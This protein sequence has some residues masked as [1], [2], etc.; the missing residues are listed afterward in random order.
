MRS[1]RDGRCEPPAPGGSN[2]TISRSSTRSR[3]GSHM[4]R[5]A[6]IPVTS[7]SGGPLP[8]RATR[9]RS[10]PASMWNGVHVT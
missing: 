2:A 9:S 5:L 10:P 8:E 3:N 1:G 7:T 6:P 4:S